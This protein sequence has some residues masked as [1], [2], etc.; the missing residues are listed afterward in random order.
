MK[1]I[2]AYKN[3]KPWSIEVDPQITLLELKRKIAEHCKRANTN[4]NII[5]GIEILDSSKNNEKLS[6]L[7]LGKIIMCV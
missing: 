1:L 5:N 7:G 6:S 2:I 3:N 4:F